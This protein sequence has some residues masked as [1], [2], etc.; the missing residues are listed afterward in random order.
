MKN[1][2]IIIDMSDD[3][4]EIT[5]NSFVADPAVIFKK[6]AFD[7][8]RLIFAQDATQQKFMGVSILAD[9]PIP[10]IHKETGEKYTVTFTK[11]AIING[12]NKMM[13]KGTQNDVSWQHKNEVVNGVFLVEN[14]ITQKG[15]IECPAFNVPDGSL[16]Q[17][18]YVA[19]K[20]Q[21]EQLMNDPT[22]GGFS[23]EIVGRL[24]EAFSSSFD[25]FYSDEK[26][27][28]DIEDILNDNSLSD[29][30]KF[31]MIKKITYNY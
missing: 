2:N 27:V 11:D 4:T 3:D 20:N 1:Y 25:E 29:E 24:E 8:E 7:N 6:L 18:Y 17:T 14:F 19:D 28:S 10:R 26:R 15:R 9:T 31:E 13:M 21:Y 16:I 12:V 5:R 22:F 30:L 23:V